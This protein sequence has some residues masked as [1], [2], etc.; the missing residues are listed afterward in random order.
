MTSF[1]LLQCSVNKAFFRAQ[2]ANGPMIYIIQHFGVSPWQIP[3]TPTHGL[4]RHSTRSS[5]GAHGIPRGGP[6]ASMAG[7][8]GFPGRPPKV[9]WD[10]TETTMQLNMAPH[11]W[12]PTRD[13]IK[14]YTI[15]LTSYDLLYLAHT[16]VRVAWHR[17]WVTTWYPAWYPAWCSAWDA[18]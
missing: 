6:W 16:A 17:T 4:P 14:R 8:V 18:K 12:D 15:C 11:A 9:P 7:H 10:L 2:R 3:W 13:G 5:V 1:L